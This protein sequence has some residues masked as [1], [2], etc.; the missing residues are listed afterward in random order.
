MARLLPA[1][2]KASLIAF[3]VVELALLVTLRTVSG[4]AHLRTVQNVSDMSA[5][6]VAA[7]CSET[8]A[9][10]DDFWPAV[11]LLSVGRVLPLPIAQAWG[12][13]PVLVGI[14]HDTCPAVAA[15]ASIVPAPERTLQ[16]GAAADAVTNIRRQQSELS[17]ADSQLQSGWSK[18]QMFETGA[19]GGDARLAR[20]ARALGVARDQQADVEDALAF[21]APERLETFL[22]GDAPRA[23]VLSVVDDAPGTQA[24]AVLDQ[25]RVTATD[26]GQPSAAPAAIV[27]VNRAGLQSLQGTLSHAQI[28]PGASDAEV[29]RALLVEF[30]RLQ[31]ADEQ[32]VVA[33]LKHAAD[34]H[35]A[36]L[37][38]DDPSLQDMVARRGWL[39]V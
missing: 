14:A 39:R 24:Y 32:N 9:A 8:V 7:T 34:D 26:V 16:D 21:L 6:T 3:C 5:A 36:W 29:A 1:W 38:F 30:T 28:A 19:L 12:Q 23:I 15:Y 10:I 18:L 22:G 33:V 37:W 31:F 2:A 4:V 17:A 35:N 11:G 13:V 20:A 27:S 25:G